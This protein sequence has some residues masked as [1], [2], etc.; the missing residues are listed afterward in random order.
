MRSKLSLIFLGLDAALLSAI[1]VVACLVYVNSVSTSAAT[2]QTASQ[3]KTIT[4]ATNTLLTNGKTASAKSAKKTEILAEEIK[5]LIQSG[6][7]AGAEQSKAAA[8]GIKKGNQL[9]NQALSLL[10][11]QIKINRANG[12]KTRQILCNG[13]VL[14]HPTSTVIKKLCSK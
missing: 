9:L 4:N 12:L 14:S 10:V 7:S 8:E 13:A 6:K 3:I 11:G 5:A 1:L 2:A